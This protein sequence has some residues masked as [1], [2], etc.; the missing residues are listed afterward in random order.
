MKN[1]TIITK[2]IYVK[3]N[4]TEEEIQIIRDNLKENEVLIILQERS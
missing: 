4:K 3:N 1:E 2:I